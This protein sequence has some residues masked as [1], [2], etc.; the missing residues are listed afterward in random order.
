MNR[1]LPLPENRKH[2]R[3]L[4]GC[5]ILERFP[6]GLLIAPSEE[7]F[8]SPINF[9]YTLMVDAPKIFRLR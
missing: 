8:F 5:Y 6:T 1:D 3:T 2:A 7:V 4:V 9:D